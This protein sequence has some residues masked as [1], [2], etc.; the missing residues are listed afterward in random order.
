MV[1]LLPVAAYAFLA[2]AM[3]YLAVKDIRERRVPNQTLIALVAVW[4][5]WRVALAVLDRATV[6][7]SLSRGALAAA[8]LIGLLVFGAAYERLRGKPAMGGGDVKLMSVLALYLGAQSLAACV[9][10]A[11]VVS[12]AFA[13]AQSWQH[14]MRS[15]GIPFATCL[16]CGVFATCL[17]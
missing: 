3:L 13:V 6:A 7:A 1:V 10:I 11:C 12:L 8:V 17:L 4:V 14:G 15:R 5:I 16:C 2:A 9:V